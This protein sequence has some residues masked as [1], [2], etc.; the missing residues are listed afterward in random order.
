MKHVLIKFVSSSLTFL[1]FSTA[2]CQENDQSGTNRIE[3]NSFLI[4]E[5]YNQDPGVVQHINNFQFMKDH[6]WFYSFT[7]EWPVPGEKHQLSYSIPVIGSGGISGLGDVL[8]NYRYQAVLTDCIGFSP[9]LSLIFPTGNYRT[10]SGTGT[11]GYQVSLPVSLTLSSKFVTHYNLGATFTF[12]AKDPE[13]VKSDITMINYGASV[14]WLTSET[15]NIFLEMVGNTTYTKAQGNG[16]VLTNSFILN[17][18]FRY[19]VNFKSGLQILPGLAIPVS[20]APLDGNIGLFVY[21]SF[22]GPIWKA[23]G[24]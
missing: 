17:P 23:K 12:G 15:F 22:E 16:T 14:V 11:F 2:Y 19:A 18:G 5:A 3:D 21:L 8:F 9:R 1:I 10:G 6:T 24:K 4:E 20:V 7:Q 13:G